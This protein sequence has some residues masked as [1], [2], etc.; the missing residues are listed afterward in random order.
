MQ[1]CPAQEPTDGDRAPSE[2]PRRPLCGL[3]SL[4]PVHGWALPKD[5]LLWN[6][7]YT[8]LATPSLAFAFECVA[9]LQLLFSTRFLFVYFFFPFNLKESV[10][11]DKIIKTNLPCSYWEY[12]RTYEEYTRGLFFPA[13]IYMKYCRKQTKNKTAKQIARKRHPR[14]LLKRFGFQNVYIY[15]MASILL[16]CF[17]LFTFKNK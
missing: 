4:L 14:S 12:A 15:R 2:Q 10:K 5:G 3:R 17:G 16:Y 6:F 8:L 9:S 1:R 11:L 7:P 13:D